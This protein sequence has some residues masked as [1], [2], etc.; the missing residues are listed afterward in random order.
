MHGSCL[1]LIRRVDGISVA[2]PRAKA[3]II[4]RTPVIT[5]DVT[6]FRGICQ[7]HPSSMARMSKRG[8]DTLPPDRIENLLRGPTAWGYRVGVE[9]PIT[10][11]NTLTVGNNCRSYMTGPSSYS[12]CRPQRIARLWLLLPECSERS[13]VH[14]S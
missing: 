14:T 13:P 6:D 3:G 5:P 9:S 4:A 2:F 12:I 7:C 1:L 8:G 10:S 11:L